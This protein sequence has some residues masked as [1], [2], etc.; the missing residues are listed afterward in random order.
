[1]KNATDNKVASHLAGSLYDMIAADPKTI[2][3][4]GEWNNLLLKVNNG[5][6]IHIM[7]GTKVVEYNL[8][9]PEWD[10]LVQNSKFKN[11]PG[12]I[13]GIAKEGYIGLQDHGYTIW[14]RNI[15][16]REIK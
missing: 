8:W 6:V 11:F 15:K 5:N 12:F 10:E 14:F 7:N 1:M 2:N 13:E 9:T 16:I 3:P 4:A